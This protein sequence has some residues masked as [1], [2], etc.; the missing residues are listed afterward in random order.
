MNIVICFGHNNVTLEAIR[1]LEVCLPIA[2]QEM[3]REEVIAKKTT[4]EDDF[5][6]HYGEKFSNA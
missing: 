5:L 2:K 1:L 6:K 3:L 4:E